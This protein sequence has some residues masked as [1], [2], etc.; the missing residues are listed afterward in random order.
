MK[1]KYMKYISC[2]KLC[3][4]ILSGLL[5]LPSFSLHAQET[6]KKKKKKKP[7]VRWEAELDLGVSYDDNILKYSEKYL[8]RFINNED[9]GRFHINTYDDAIIFTSAA[10]SSTIKIF[11]KQ[12]SV[13]NAE[14][15][16]R[17]Y[18]VNSVKNWNYFTLGYRQYIT[19]KLSFKFL[20]SYIP[21]FYVR[22]FRDEQWIEVY[23]YNP[24][25]FT[26]YV[27]SKD[28]Y[29]FYVQNTFF[30]N[31]RVKFALYYAPYY[32]NKHYTEYDS[33]NWTYSFQLYQRIVKNFR[34][35]LRYEYLT[36]DAKGY[37]ESIETPETTQGPDA[38]YVEDRYSA[39][40]LWTLPKVKKFRHSFD[41]EA[42]YFIRY[43]SSPHPWQID[44]LHAG[45][46]DKN[47][48]I[49]ANYKFRWNKDWQ[50]TAFYNWMG[51]DSYSTAELNDEFVSNEKD[52][53]Q[54][55]IGLKLAYSIS[56]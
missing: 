24:N 49:Y 16:R 52:Y 2:K 18:V 43:Y 6:D 41:A 34:L 54:N 23:G 56:F 14:V 28:N 45:R 25:T 53:K 22:H 47:L 3:L 55:I 30:K 39:G 46:V 44:R 9:E 27:F 26:P 13:F 37:D 29:G 10:L 31:T 15:S 5:I 48:R 42:L 40:F 4:L 50:F 11:G 36:S 20:Y 8:T 51:R 17:T 32:H 33:K 12:N 1:T 19:K 7:K 35:D 38:T 21:E